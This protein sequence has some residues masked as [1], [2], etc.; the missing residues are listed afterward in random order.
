[1]SIYAGVNDDQKKSQSPGKAKQN[2]NGGTMGIGVAS[3]H[4][5]PTSLFAGI[6]VKTLQ[7]NY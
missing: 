3:L 4:S 1:M 2:S 5:T 6:G 7:I